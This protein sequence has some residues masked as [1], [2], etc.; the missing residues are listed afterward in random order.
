MR[1]QEMI[2]RRKSCRSFTGILV[3]QEVLETI[4]AFPMRPL[5]PQIGAYE[6]D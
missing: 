1:L 3:A 4:K 6:P 2:Y 5:Y